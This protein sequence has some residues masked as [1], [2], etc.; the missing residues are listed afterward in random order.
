MATRIRS[1]GRLR[2]LSRAQQPPSPIL[3][4]DEP[5]IFDAEELDPESEDGDQVGVDVLPG[6]A[7]DSEAS[8]G[9]ALQ[10]ARVDPE[11]E[12]IEEEYQLDDEDDEIE[13]EDES[14]T[15]SVPPKSSLKIKLKMGAT[16][17]TRAAPNRARVRR[18]RV[19]RI[20][21][22]SSES[23][24]EE[25]PSNTRLT[26]RQA[27]LAKAKQ[28]DVTDSAEEEEDLDVLDPEP[29]PEFAVSSP[30]GRGVRSSR[31]ALDPTELALRKEESARKRRNVNERK[32]QNEKTETINRLLKKQSRPRKNL[33]KGSAPGPLGNFS[34]LVLGAGASASTDVQTP[35]S[36]RGIAFGAGDDAGISVAG[37]DGGHAS[38]EPMYRWVSTTRP[39]TTAGE[40]DM[41]GGSFPSQSMKLSFSIPAAALQHLSMPLLPS[42]TQRAPAICA[43]EGC[44]KDRRYR[45]VGAEWG[46]GACGIGHLKVLEM[47]RVP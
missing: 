45:L 3:A 12:E 46:V 32:L 14:R 21:S 24:E 15:P 44:G 36:E 19:I 47:E 18:G 33:K 41:D 40:E 11:Q 28:I 4:D 1:S 35:V 9:D 6:V 7:S 27:A 34:A 2:A 26:K 37:I 25:M 31:A 42:S 39:R 38:A 30:A 13:M 8:D 23:S 43:V 16:T 29:E 17:R 10:V 20:Q 5:D 22:E